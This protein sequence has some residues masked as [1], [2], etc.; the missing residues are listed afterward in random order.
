MEHR[1]ARRPRVRGYCGAAAYPGSG[2]ALPAALNEQNASLYALCVRRIKRLSSIQLASTRG[3]GA[4]LCRDPRCWQTALRR[5]AL[6]GALK[7]ELRTEDRGALLK[8]AGRPGSR[9]GGSTYGRKTTMSPR[10]I[11]RRP[12]QRQSNRRGRPVGQSRGSR[13]RI[14]LRKR[15]NS[16][17]AARRRNN[18]GDHGQRTSPH[19]ST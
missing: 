4:Y 17:R 11:R 12:P 18:S 10:Q 19:C 7:T 5:N 8:F 6:S 15:R 9:V 16:R 14:S 1:R 2:P 3:R 13:R